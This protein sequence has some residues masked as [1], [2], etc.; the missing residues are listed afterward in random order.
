MITDAELEAEALSADPETPVDDDAVSFFDLAPTP[1]ALVGDWYMPAPM[2]RH[3]DG[4]R[5]LC[6]FA[7]VATFLLIEAAG[8]CSTYG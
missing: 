6:V 5:R 2:A 8:L 4:W 7:L 1:S 3:L